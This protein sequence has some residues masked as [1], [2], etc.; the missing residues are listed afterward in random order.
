MPEVFVRIRCV[1]RMAPWVGSLARR[2]GPREGPRVLSL[3]VPLDLL[4]AAETGIDRE[5]AVV[6]VVDDE[7]LQATSVLGH[8]VCRTDETH[9][10]RRVRKA[11]VGRE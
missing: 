7:R 11:H 1:V 2:R 6:S 10:F 3:V 8:A 5:R 9:R 4:R